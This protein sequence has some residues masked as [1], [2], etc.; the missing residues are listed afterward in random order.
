MSSLGNLSVQS[1]NCYTSFILVMRNYLSKSYQSSI[2]L[3]IILNVSGKGYASLPVAHTEGPAMPWVFLLLRLHLVHPSS[4]Q[5][6]WDLSQCLICRM[7]QT[8]LPWSL[9]GTSAWRISKSWIVS[10]TSAWRTSKSWILVSL[11]GT[12][13]WRFGETWTFGVS[14][15]LVSILDSGTQWLMPTCIATS[16]ELVLI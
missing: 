1:L 9:P 11:R 13:T 4:S 12:S 5:L 6:S 7:W 15:T 3:I 10:G 8:Q 14:Q 2:L 16:N